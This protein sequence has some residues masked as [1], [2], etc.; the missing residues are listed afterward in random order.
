MSKDNIDKLSLKR[1]P[2]IEKADLFKGLISKDKA[3]EKFIEIIEKN[4]EIIEHNLKAVDIASAILSDDKNTLKHVARM[5]IERDV[6]KWIICVP[7]NI[8]NKEKKL[9]E[10]IKKKEAN[11]GNA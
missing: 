1:E 4:I 7:E 10:K 5:Q 8:I 3:W 6:M 11:D 2:L 9:G